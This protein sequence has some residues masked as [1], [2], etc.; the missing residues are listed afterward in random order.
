MDFLYSKNVRIVY[1]I[2]AMILR[3]TLPASRINCHARVCICTRDW[4]LSAEE[5]GS[6]RDDHAKTEQRRGGASGTEDVAAVINW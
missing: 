5:E 1:K 4:D 6:T 3:V 2:S